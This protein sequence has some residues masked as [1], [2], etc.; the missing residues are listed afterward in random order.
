MQPLTLLNLDYKILSC[1]L[2]LRMKAV[3]PKIIEEYQTGFMENRQIA[4]N[5]CTTVDIVTHINHTRQRALIISID[6]EKC[7]DRKEHKSIYRALRHFNFGERFI[8][9]TSLFFT[10]F[11]VCTQ[12]AGLLSEF[13]SK[14]RGV[15]QGCPISP[16]CYLVCSAIM[17]HMIVQNTAIT[18]IFMNNVEYVITQSA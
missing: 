13:M 18:G 4:S 9:W 15:N 1:T 11:S 14:T 5:I 3:L 17:A 2:A 8:K 6:F 10:D 12:N 16:F 7:F